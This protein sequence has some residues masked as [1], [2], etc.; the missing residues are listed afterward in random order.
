MPRPKGLAKQRPQKA[1]VLPVE[2]APAVVLSTEEENAGGAPVV[3]AAPASQ[4]P[5]S[6]AAVSS[7]PDRK[8]IEEALVFANADC[9]RAEKELKHF[10]AKEKV[11]DAASHRLGALLLGSRSA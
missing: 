10:K 2:S 5:A 11:Y 9:D 8:R 7:S 1:K 3:L 4:P 6:C